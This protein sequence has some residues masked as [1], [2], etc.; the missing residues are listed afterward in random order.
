MD[1]GPYRML[2]KLEKAQ[3]KRFKDRFEL[4][5]WISAILAKGTPTN[6]GVNT[7]SPLSQRKRADAVG[8]KAPATESGIGP[9]RAAAPPLAYSSNCE[10]RRN[11]SRM[12]SR[13]RS[14]RRSISLLPKTPPCAIPISSAF[15]VPP[16]RP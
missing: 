11:A 5:R 3:S 6:E 7:S 4:F 16:L 10:V 9:T 14:L 1:F 2:R 13:I 15:L 8:L 12:P